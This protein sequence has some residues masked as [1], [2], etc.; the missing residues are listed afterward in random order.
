[1][2]GK[3]VHLIGTLGQG[4]AERQVTYLAQ[5]LQQRGWPQCVIAFAPGGVWKDR[6]LE[7]QIVVGEVPPSWLKPWRLWRLY[8]LLRGESPEILVSWS[9]HVAVYNWSLGWSSRARRVFNVR[10]N[11]TRSSRTGEP[12]SLSRFY[13]LAL[14]KSHY[15][16]SNARA[17][18]E[19]LQ[20]LGVRL[21]PQRVIRNIVQLGQAADASAQVVTPRIVAVGSLI[22]R[23]AFDV[24]LQALGDLRRQELPF[25]LRIAGEGP[26][27]PALQAIAAELDL[28]KRVQ[29][30][31]N[32]TDVPGLL[33]TAHLAVHASKSEGLS[34]AI[35]EAMAA[36]LPVVAT[37]VDG[38]AEVIEDEKTG[39]LVPPG[40]P[41]SLATAIR[42]LILDPALR[43]RLG[44]AARRDVGET[45]SADGVADAYE[46]VFRELLAGVPRSAVGQ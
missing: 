16:V 6:L 28:A 38:A 2:T 8:R 13:R 30:L 37:A 18:L 44:V 29:F 3:V 11:L 35:L 31:G 24:L 4:G 27:A 10:F 43:G 39:I 26:E 19:S 32:V 22:R 41:K 15:A 45:C 36:G 5:A 33:A 14:E 1:M 46:A 17:T 40:D 12:V 20:D 25:E 23:K 9:S 21:P 7:R 34:N 42:R